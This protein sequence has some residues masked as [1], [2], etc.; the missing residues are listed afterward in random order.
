MFV[1]NEWESWSNRSISRFVFRFTD[2]LNKK[3]KRKIGGI[4]NIFSGV[5]VSQ[6]MAQ[7]ERAI[8]TAAGVQGSPVPNGSQVIVKIDK[9]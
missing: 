9:R 5:S 6:L 4:G 8:V 7:R 1:L 2:G 3:K